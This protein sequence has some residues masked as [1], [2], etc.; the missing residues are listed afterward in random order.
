[1]AIASFLKPA[2]V[3]ANTDSYRVSSAS[4]AEIQF[5]GPAAYRRM[6][7]VF[8]GDQDSQ[9]VTV[10]FPKASIEILLML[11][12]SW[13]PN[14]ITKAARTTLWSVGPNGQLIT[15][16]NPV[17]LVR[18]NQWLIELETFKVIA[19]FYETLVNDNANINEKDKFNWKIAE[20]RFQS[21][22]SDVKQA[23]HFYDVN[24]DGVISKIEENN[25]MDINY[26]SEDR[27]YF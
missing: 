3:L 1:M 21:R 12:E 14:Y 23:S 19:N 13:W 26:Y 20:E 18:P 8:K 10:M 27:R 24:S 15:G 5:Y 4:I 25:D 6:D 9:L 16:F 17:L 2:D 22:W 7:Q 11:E